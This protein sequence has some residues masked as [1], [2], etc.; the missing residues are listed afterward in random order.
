MRSA[1]K[2]SRAGIEEVANA[3]TAIEQWPINSAV[4]YNEW[5]ASLQR[6]DFKPVV[7]AFEKLECQFGCPDCG[8]PL[9]I[10]RISKKND[11]LRCGCS[12]VNLNLNQ[13]F[14]AA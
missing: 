13:K 7:A 10:V 6:E 4:H 11:A 2:G 14:K 12:K 9:Y 8:E 1:H 5:A 3:L